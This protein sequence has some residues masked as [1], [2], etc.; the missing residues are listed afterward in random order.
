RLVEHTHAVL[1]VSNS[2][3]LNHQ[4]MVVATRAYVITG[5]KQFLSSFSNDTVIF[6]RLSNKLKTLVSDNPKQQLRVDSLSALHSQYVSIRSKAISVRASPSFNLNQQTDLVSES[7]AVLKRIRKIFD[8]I[9]KDELILLDA[10][11]KTENEYIADSN[12]LI[13]SLLI[14]LVSL[15]LFSSYIIYKNI[16]KRNQ[17]EEKLQHLNQDLQI[18]IEQKTRSILEQEEEY[19]FLLE[20]M[21]EGIQIISTDWRYLFVNKSVVHQGKYAK[22]ELM[23]KT[24][25]EKYPGIEDTELF[26]V[27]Q[28]CMRDRQSQ[29]LDTEFIYPD[30]STGWFQLSIQPVPEGLFILSMDISHRKTAEITLKDSEEKRRLMMNAALDAIICMDTDGNITFWNPQAER[31]F[32]WQNDEVQLKQLADFIIP[33][34]FRDLHR[35]GLKKYLY[36]GEGP[37]LNTTIETEGLN[38]AGRMF[39]IEISIIPIKQANEQFFCAFIRDISSRK[40][41]ELQ[42]MNLN[43]QLEKR[44]VEL[45]T[46]NRE[47]EHFAYV[48]SHDLQE[49]LR[50]VRSF[51]ALLETKLKGRLDETTTQYIQFAMDGADRM[52]QLIQDLLKYSRI[53]PIE[54]SLKPVNIGKTVEDVLRIYQAIL[55]ETKAVV[56][57]PVLPIVIGNSVQLSQLFQNIIGNAIKYRNE[58]TP[59]I[60]IGFT[61]QNE[62]W[63][64]YVKDNGIGIEK[65]YYDKIF[66]IF[67]RL[68][69]RSQYEGTG[70][71]LAICKKIVER[72]GGK[73]WVESEP[74]AGSTFYFT[75]KK[76]IDATRN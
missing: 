46:S 17:A 49:P 66:T 27:L 62:N 55:S 33:E 19:R 8:S 47:L 71:G 32:G 70:V 3:L 26:K 6:R 28:T 18:Q 31:I 52:K 34:Q 5:E 20:N 30:K 16:L 57:V 2:I 44:A 76:E 11:K 40:R 15:L 36:T 50:M 74:R 39:P 14:I 38:K 9:N 65:K 4:D 59:I 73:I 45:E 43:M 64:F 21:Q 29:L 12:T 41:S 48:A 13:K 69:N 35:R 51:V 60:E 61:E 53:S 23:G 25:M 7:D 56:K 24:M 22:E 54:E 1:N 72:H 75:I 63:L 37:Y 67:Q 58:H 68:H 10:A 42:L